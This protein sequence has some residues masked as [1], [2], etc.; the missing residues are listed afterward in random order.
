MLFRSRDP[1]VRD[2]LRVVFLPNF[3]VT[4]GQRIYPAADLS[5]QISLAGKEASG[6]GNMKFA[7]N[8]ALTIGTMDGANI[9]IREQVGADHFFLFGM[10]AAEVAQLKAGGYRPGDWLARNAELNE[11]INLIRHGYFSRGDGEL[12]QPLLDSLVHHDPYCLFADFQSYSDAHVR[13]GDAYLDV[14][15]WTRMSILNSARSGL[16]S[17]DRTIAQYCDE[18]WNVKPVMVPLL[19]QEDVRVEFMS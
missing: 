1:A 7:L 15:D 3:S 14:E 18:I 8:G 16:F 10:D 4:N 11:V 19:S 2:K 17:S 13:A 9:E 6:T 5:E 12:F